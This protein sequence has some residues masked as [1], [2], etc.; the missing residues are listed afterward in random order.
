VNV[1]TASAEFIGHTKD[2]ISTGRRQG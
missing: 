2:T 1:G